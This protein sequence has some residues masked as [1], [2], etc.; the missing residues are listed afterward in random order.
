MQ[1]PKAEATIPRRTESGPSP[2]SFAQQR[3]WFLSQ[4]ESDNWSYNVPASLRLA[5][6]LDVAAFQQ[7]LNTIVERHEILRTTFA[8][9]DGQPVQV[10]APAQIVPLPLLD[11]QTLPPDEREAEARRMVA[12]E[13][14]RPFDLARGPLI[15]ASLLRLSAEDH[16][17]LLTLHHIVADGWSI[18]VFI[19]ELIA[20]Y[21]AFA[22][23]T[24]P[25]LPELPIQYAD[26]A[27]WQRDW[28]Q[29]AELENQLAYWRRQLADLVPLE[30]P[31]DYQRPPVP[32]F[33][34]AVQT[35]VLPPA[36]SEGLAA[37]SRRQDATL[38]MTLLT[39]F[40][41][42]LARYTGQHDIV[43]GSPIAGRMRAEVADLMGCFVNTLVLR[44]DL[45]GNPTF[46]ELLGRVRQTA[47]DAY[48]HQDLPF[49]QV[50][51][52]LQPERDLSRNP[53]F[54]VMFDLQ[55]APPSA[56]ELP[57]LAMVPLTLEH[58]TEKFDLSLSF[59]E[60]EGKLSGVLRYSTDLFAPATIAQMLA[61]FQTL[62]HGIVA[63][64]GRPIADLPLLTEAEQ[65]QLRAEN[66]SATLAPRNTCV[67]DLFAAQAAR[68]PEAV[69]V[70]FGD[71]SLT[72]AEL[73][74]RANQLAH[75]LRRLGVGPEVRVGLY[76]QR[77][78]DLV[79]ALLGIWKAGGAYVPLDPSYP[80]QRLAF[81][82]ADA[83]IAVVLTQQDL[84][85]TVPSEIQALCLDRDWERIAQADASAPDTG[86]QPDHLAYVI[87]TSGST[88]Q[89][90][91]VLV[92]HSNLLATLWASQT[93]FQFQPGDV[94][95]WIA[96]ATFD[97]ALFELFNPLLAGG[98][99][100]VL[101]QEQV[102]DLPRLCAT[103]AGCTVVHSVPS[104]MRQI[105]QQIRADGRDAHAY[106]QLRMIFVGGELVP[107]ELL[108]EMQAT[109]PQ[110]QIFVLY[111]PT[112][113]TIICTAYRVEAG[114]IGSRALIGVPLPSAQVRL[115]DRQGHLVP[116]GVVGE[117]YIG[118]AGVTRGYLHRPEL[119]AE[120]FVELDRQ[121]WYKSGDLGRC[122]ADGVIEFLGRSD[123]Q[124]KVRG[125]RIEL[126]EVAAVLSKHPAVRE[127]VV[128][129]QAAPEGEQRLVAY[130]VPDAEIAPTVRELRS[131]VGTHLPEY[132][133]PAA[134]VLLPA[135][136]LTAHG[137]LDRKA[138]PAPDGDGLARDGRYVA[139]RTP[140]EE[141]LAG[142]W[143]DVLHLE[144]VSV[145]ED[146]FALCGHSLL[147]T[148]VVARVREAFQVEL[149]L[150]SLFEKP[151]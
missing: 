27:V 145:Q 62:L 51:E 45:D 119:S 70:V 63:D 47:L 139:P 68:T 56:P 129:A 64:P 81:L 136:P 83:E 58:S 88:G 28:L 30:L 96:S 101:S 137:K 114:L 24:T 34:G 17:L 6:A 20:L 115:Y 48:A 113:A 53:L 148:Q 43:V 117:I 13:L 90:K 82:L 41:V 59:E 67:H 107:P 144:R 109:F 141:V 120:K 106:D 44:T 92:N 121:R 138:L 98:T 49:E 131:F 126:G 147:A 15:R 95:P 16:V 12:D 76:L 14:R 18:G 86:V 36:I 31:A 91:G 5:G 19:R 73:D 103:L 118:G 108:A 66:P 37:I 130:V 132:M 9:A 3:L 146:F 128:V 21:G 2:L 29:G 22:K 71:R 54:Q 50:V 134:F 116:R 97:I 65:Q 23:G 105:V 11:L 40:Q 60:A 61:H 84:A 140:I 104:L 94:M 4:L 135:L 25:A 123:E 39:A 79:V 46:A 75:E 42:L 32:S 89:P 7:S 150:R 99:A 149:P 33:R 143:A 10:I 87:Y 35:F 124:V 133:V 38:F 72:Y 127:S 151:T 8:T 57:G 111:G 85:A 69:A 112:E 1:V 93:A 142:I 80:A 78:L 125:Y 74:R 26:Y 55:N 100:L 102:L 110:A 122:R 52:A 77:S